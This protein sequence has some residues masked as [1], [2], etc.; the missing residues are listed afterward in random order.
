[1][2]TAQ[3]RIEILIGSFGRTSLATEVL[4]ITPCFPPGIQQGL[5]RY[6]RVFNTFMDAR[7]GALAGIL[8]TQHWIAALL[9]DGYEAGGRLNPICWIGVPTSPYQLA[10]LL[11]LACAHFSAQDGLWQDE[12][13][14]ADANTIS[15]RGARTSIAAPVWA[16]SEAKRERDPVLQG[17]IAQ[18]A[19]RLVRRETR[20]A[21]TAAPAPSADNLLIPCATALQAIAAKPG[22][23][24]LI[25]R[26]IPSAY[27]HHGLGLAR[28]GYL[29][30]ERFRG[31]RDPLI[32][33][34]SW[35]L[36]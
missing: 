34:L 20:L 14:R 8:V 28:V 26:A 25:V 6:C 16:A 23:G 10:D 29:G 18:V 30:D 15:Q 2:S 9:E 12:R 7:H 24:V 35:P 21:P 19:E 27:D 3:S 13:W 22:L 33:T 4:G 17:R 31:A 36:P 1:M 11:T 32:A 5:A